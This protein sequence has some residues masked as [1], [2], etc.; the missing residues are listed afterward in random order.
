MS[1]WDILSLERAERT[2]A[3]ASHRLQLVQTQEQLRKLALELAQ[4]RQAD[5]AR[6]AIEGLK[7]ASDAHRKVAS[8]LAERYGIGW[9]THSY[10][11]ETG[12]ILE[13]SPE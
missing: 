9:Q 5:E 3:D 4:L 11:P 6:A 7:Q 12:E 13:S 10:H 8:E 2:A 1:P